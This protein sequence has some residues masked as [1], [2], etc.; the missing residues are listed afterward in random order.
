MSLYTARRVAAKLLASVN[1][2]PVRGGSW[3]ALALLVVVGQARAQYR[4]D[5]FTTDNGLPQ[6]TVAAI[7]QTRDGYLW[8]ATYD[9]L[10]RYD[11]V[12]FTIF[13]KGSNPDI[14]CNWF[15][16]LWKDPQG[17]LWAGTVE[18]G[19]LRYRDGVFRAFT[20]NDGLP[21]KSI[22][23]IQ[24]AQSGAPLIFFSSGAYLWDDDRLSAMPADPRDLRE[25]E[26]AFGTRWVLE[27]DAL[28]RFKEDVRTSFPVCLT[29][30]DFVQRRFV[31][32]SG[33]LW[34]GTSVNG[35][36]HIFGEELLHC[37]GGDGLPSDTLIQIGGEDREGNAW[38]F[39]KHELFRHKDG[40]FTRVLSG[41]ELKTQHIRAVFCDREGTVW[42]GTNDR[43]LFRLSRPFLT[44]YA[45]NDGLLDRIVYPILEDRAGTIWIGSG[46]GLTQFA[47]GRFT[48]RPLVR[49]APGGQN[50]VAFAS[51]NDARPPV[52]VHCLFEDQAGRL[53]LGSG[54]GLFVLEGGSFSDRSELADHTTV[55]ACLEDRAG[56]LW[57]GT[58]KGLFRSRSGTRS[59][60]T[61]KDGLPIQSVT[62]LHQDRRGDLWV[63][64]R[65]GLVRKQ[66]EQFVAVG[67]N[68]GLAGARIRC[69]HEEEG[70]LWVG[71]F[72]CGLWRVQDD[73]VVHYT[74]R[75][76]LHSN[77]VFQILA[78]HRGN[79]W[80][81]C[82]RGIYRV[83]RSQ[84][85]DYAAGKTSAISCVPY[86]CEDGML[87]TEC[88]GERP[89]AGVQARD[90]K[91]WFPTM[92]GVVVVD[93]DAV[94]CNPLPP[95]VTIES[96]EVDR[97]QVGIADGVRLRP[98][99]TDLELH[100]TAPSFVKAD[101][102]NFKYRLEGLDEAW[103]DAGT[104]RTVHYSHLPPGRYTLQVIAANSDGVWNDAAAE[105]DV[106]VM[107]YFYQKHWFRALCIVGTM[108][109]V[110]GVGAV[111][112]R[113]L[114]ANARRLARLVTE[115]TAEL[116]ER[117]RQL[118]SANDRLKELAT[119][120]GLTGIAN[121]RRFQEFLGQE[122]QRSQRTQSPLALLLMDVDYFKRFNDA[123]GHQ[124]GDDCLRR[125]AAVLRETA[126]RATD[127]T[128]RY[129][130]EEFAVVLPDTGPDGARAVA[131]TIR[132]RIEA[133][134]ISHGASQASSFVTLSIGIATSVAEH[135]AVPEDLIAA[136]DRALYR[137]KEQGRNCCAEAASRTPEGVAV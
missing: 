130:G 33:G 65:A 123:H 1:P 87:S 78:D 96:A 40:R 122:W 86:G 137:A 73:N 114:K 7:T 112:V 125:V 77:G 98:G 115:R 120:D 105:L 3:T 36:C 68:E 136:A 55:L 111:W 38:L 109:L 14:R 92:H 97:A 50:A 95:L 104:R 81:S 99:Q 101:H 76:G 90:G 84:L 19:L 26:D 23:N 64:T 22:P 66:G 20:T 94:S 107:P 108:S 28:L 34:V 27:P 103:V 46:R 74:T 54:S 75:V 71:T 59:L 63:G 43:G 85:D 133:L 52:D 117:T 11:G 119:T 110:A 2:L 32:H 24:G 135:N 47:D 51:S 5:R 17:T 48:P 93:P 44:T 4:F 58:E 10:V 67:A 83:R 69:F 124:S 45:E 127:L 134:R 132:S 82:N 29:V 6:N 35:V 16:S 18:G 70:V 53:W 25:F 8:L 118:E 49:S 72:D 57:L 102:M 121:H 128:A 129:G 15:H 42:V 31:D 60:Y 116:A 39:S 62:V 61:Q 13:D 131:E 89:P 126:N 113:A 56:D 30:N 88:N 80:L 21:D 91:L 9:G 79:F 12:H 41:D 37:T 100:Y 106:E